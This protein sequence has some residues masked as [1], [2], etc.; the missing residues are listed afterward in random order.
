MTSETVR[1]RG[2][3]VI[4]PIYPMT[5]DVS[6]KP[7]GMPLKQIKALREVHFSLE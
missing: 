5:F 2:S 3:M 4:W 6:E 7:F 1:K